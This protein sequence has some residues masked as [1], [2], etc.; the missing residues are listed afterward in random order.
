MTQQFE[1]ILAGHSPS[2]YLFGSAVLDDFRL[3]WSDIDILCFAQKP[4]ID[5]QANK[6]L[7]LRQAMLGQWP[8]NPY[9]RSF[10]GIITGWDVVASA[11]KATVVYWGTS[12]Q[13][14]M[15]SFTIDAFSMIGLLRHGQLRCGI[16]HRKRLSMPSRVELYLAIAEH[17]ATIRKYAKQTDGR[18]YSAGWLFDIARCLYTLRTGDIMAKTKA[19]L[20]A[21][22][23]GLAPEPEILRRAIQ[24]REQPLRCQ[25]NTTRDWLASL[26]PS[27]QRFADVLEGALHRA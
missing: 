15:D 27:V 20:W 11:S 19:G 13:R 5:A 6:L 4:L 3:G 7:E 9:F 2:V 16:D 10:E 24:V 1:C 23:Q 21:L 12:G 8:Q 22:E 17:L 14:I 26:G 25:D 18:V